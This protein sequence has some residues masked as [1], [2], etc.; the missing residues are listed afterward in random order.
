MQVE[1]LVE[2]ADLLKNSKKLCTENVATLEKQARRYATR[3]EDAAAF[4]RSLDR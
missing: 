3:L 2:F 4:A 1:V